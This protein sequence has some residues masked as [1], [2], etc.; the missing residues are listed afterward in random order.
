MARTKAPK[1]D[2]ELEI[3][4][5]IIAMIEAGD[6][7]KWTR[8]WAKLLTGG[9]YCPETKRAYEGFT[10]IF[11]LNVQSFARGFT[12]QTWGTYN[13]WFALGGGEKDNGKVTKDSDFNVR[14]GEKAVYIFVPLMFNK[15][16]KAGNV[17]TDKKGNEVKGLSFKQVAVFNGEQVD[18]YEE[19]KPEMPA[20]AVVDNGALDRFVTN[21]NL[22]ITHA[23]DRAFYS[24]ATDSITIPLQEAFIA[25]PTSTATESYYGTLLHEATHATGHESRCKRALMNMNGSEAYAKEELIAELGAAML[26][27]KMGISD[28]PRPDH[29]QYIKSWLKALKGDKKFIFQAVSGASKAIK[30]MDAQQP[31]KMEK[32][33]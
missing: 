15:K 32:A 30:W 5:T 7:G 31:V 22:S 11:A 8:P 16:D 12:S 9:H 1:V 23:G 24:P 25:T 28:S 10:N 17:I 4:N 27:N 26:A 20:N 33:A 21:L 19:V 14:K 18:G 2:A 29:A 13:Q 3:T 6:M